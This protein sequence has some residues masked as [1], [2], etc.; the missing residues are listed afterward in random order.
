MARRL[1]GGAFNLLSKNL[2]GLPELL[3]RIEREKPAWITF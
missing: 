3:D 2:C 1:L